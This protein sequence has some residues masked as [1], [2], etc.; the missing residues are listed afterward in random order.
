MELQ[1]SAIFS[2]VP[3]RL[4]KANGGMFVESMVHLSRFDGKTII[5][6][7]SKAAN[8]LRSH[9]GTALVVD[10]GV[11]ELSTP[12][13][14]RTMNHVLSGVFGE[15]PQ[16]VMFTPEFAYSTGLLLDNIENLTIFAHGV[17]LM[18]DGFME[19]VAIQNCRNITIEGLSVDHKR[20]P[21]SMGVV[22]DVQWQEKEKGSFVIQ[23]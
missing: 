16:D 4:K 2:A 17:L 7:F 18:V 10:P 23:S 9:P 1:S 6:R 15:N 20:K 8:W 22:S 3:V 19:P 12:L 14:R 13:A 21:F 11:Y 5:E